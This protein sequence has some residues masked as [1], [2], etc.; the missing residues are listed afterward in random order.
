MPKEALPEPKRERAEVLN[1]TQS[2]KGGA[3]RTGDVGMNQV[4]GQGCRRKDGGKGAGL[5]VPAVGLSSNPWRG[6]N[7]A[8]IP[9]G[10]FPKRKA[11][12]RHSR[13][14]LGCSLQPAAN[15]EPLSC[16]AAVEGP[17]EISWMPRAQQIARGEPSTWRYFSFWPPLDVSSCLL[18]DLGLVVFNESAAVVGP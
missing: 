4:P 6:G 12:N 5:Q 10:P 17:P 3:V 8:A 14:L 9:A 18:S 13:N 16:R 15:L 2:D 1:S 11:R 7:P